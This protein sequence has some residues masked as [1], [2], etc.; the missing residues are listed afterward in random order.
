L[1]DVSQRLFSFGDT[2]YSLESLLQGN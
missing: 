2:D 1:H